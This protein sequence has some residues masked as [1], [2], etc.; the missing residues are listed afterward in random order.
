MAEGQLD[1]M[2]MQKFKMLSEEFFNKYE[3]V[4][5]LNIS[6]KDGFSLFF[7]SHSLDVEVDK[8]AAVSSTLYSLSNA[9]AQQLVKDEFILTSIET[10]NGNILFYQTSLYHLPCVICLI[11]SKK[12]LLAEAR[13][14][15]KKLSDNFQNLD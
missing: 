4:G 5:L 10:V 2:Q 3:N 9:T 12:V 15:V 11:V 1:Q 7:Q 6:T 8:I 13:F 14:L